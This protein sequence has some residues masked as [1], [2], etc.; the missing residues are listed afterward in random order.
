MLLDIF[1]LN[2][3]ISYNFKLVF[4]RERNQKWPY[5]SSGKKCELDFH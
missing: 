2:V 1:N 4:H 5:K 3:W